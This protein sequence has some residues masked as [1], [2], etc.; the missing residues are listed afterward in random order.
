MTITVLQSNT[1]PIFP[2]TNPTSVTIPDVSFSFY[3]NN[4]TLAGVLTHPVACI[5]DEFLFLPGLMKANN[6]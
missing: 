3:V 4:I 6:V 2:A 5:Y 1:N